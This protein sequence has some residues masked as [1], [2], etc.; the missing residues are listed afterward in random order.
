[1]DFKLPVYATYRPREVFGVFQFSFSV[2]LAAQVK[3]SHAT[4]GFG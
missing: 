1:V 3:V 4:T 2:A